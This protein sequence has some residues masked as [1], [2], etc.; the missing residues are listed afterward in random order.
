MGKQAVDVPIKFALTKAEA[1]DPDMQKSLADGMTKSLGLKDG[2]VTIISIGDEAARRRLAD[3][4]ITFQIIIEEATTTDLEANIK[5]AAEEGSI[6]AAIQE[7]ANTNGVLTQALNDMEM[8]ITAP[9]VAAKAVKTKVVRAV[10]KKPPTTTA[11]TKAPTTVKSFSGAITTSASRI[12][13]ALALCQG[14]MFVLL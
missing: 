9:A 1:K 14:L 7:E 3:L 11:P 13:L 8:K 2:Q 6:I 5:A 4:E 10:D 12:C